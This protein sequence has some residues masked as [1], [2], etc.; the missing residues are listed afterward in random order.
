MGNPL[1]Q[2]CKNYR[3]FLIYHLQALKALDGVPVVSYGVYSFN[4]MPSSEI[5]QDNFCK[6]LINFPC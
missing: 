4:I 3:L 1:V 6:Y 2:E 5:L